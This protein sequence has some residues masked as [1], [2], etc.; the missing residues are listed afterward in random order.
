MGK[1]L[2]NNKREW[3]SWQW[4]HKQLARIEMG[5]VFLHFKNEK[6]EMGKKW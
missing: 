1:V 5:E 4:Y 2:S 3:D 6:N